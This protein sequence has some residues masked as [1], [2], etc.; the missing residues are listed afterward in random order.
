[1]Y[2]TYVE[3]GVDMSKTKLRERERG[4]KQK[5]KKDN[6]HAFVE[7]YITKRKITFFFYMYTEWLVRAICGD[8]KM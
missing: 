7:K 3:I 6:K 2:Y 4:Q 1:M 5:E 8:K